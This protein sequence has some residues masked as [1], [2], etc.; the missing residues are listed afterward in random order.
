MDH[1]KDYK[2]PKDSEDIDDVTKQLREVGCAPVAPVHAPSSSEEDEQYAV[3]VKK[4]KKGEI[5]S[6]RLKCFFLYIPIALQF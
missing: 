4:A 1:V 3:P 2:P 6:D 5:E